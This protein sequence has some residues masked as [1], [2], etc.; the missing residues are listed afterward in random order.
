MLKIWGGGASAPKA[1]TVS[2]PLCRRV[3]VLCMHVYMY[4]Y[5]VVWASRLNTTK[6][7]MCTHLSFIWNRSRSHIEGN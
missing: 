3:H 6:N 5:S 4:V 1:P 7:C 2:T